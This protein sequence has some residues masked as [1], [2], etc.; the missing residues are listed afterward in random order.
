SKGTLRSDCKSD[1]DCKV[2]YSVC[3]PTT[4]RCVC[5]NSTNTHACIC[6]KRELY[7]ELGQPCTGSRQCAVAYSTCKNNVCSCQAG[8]ATIDG[9]CKSSRNYCPYF[10]KSGRRGLLSQK[11]CVQN[12][13]DKIID[14]RPIGNCSNNEYCFLHDGVRRP[15]HSKVGVCCLKPKYE[16]DEIIRVCPHSVKDPLDRSCKND[17]SSNMCSEKTHHC[18]MDQGRGICCPR[19]C[20]SFGN[21]SHFSLDGRC[22][23]DLLHGEYCTHD[24]ECPT[25]AKCKIS[26]H[27]NKDKT[28]QCEHGSSDGRHCNQPVAT[29]E[30]SNVP[31]KPNCSKGEVY[32]KCENHNDCTAHYSICNEKTKRCECHNSTQRHGCTCQKRALY[33]E[34]GQKCTDSHQ[35]AIAYSSCK[36]H[37]CTCKAGFKAMDGFCKAAG[38][39]C[40]YFR[41]TPQN[42]LTSNK[43]CVR[44][45]EQETTFNARPPGNC[46]ETEY[47]LIHDGVRTFQHQSVGFCCPRPYHQDDQTI[48]VCP[49]GIDDPQR[50]FCEENFYWYENPNA[51]PRETHRCVFYEEN[52]DGRCYPEA[53]HGEYCTVDIQCTYEAKCKASD[54]NKKDKTCQCDHGAVNGGGCKAPLEAA[55]NNRN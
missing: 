53:F 3:N 10:R 44:N 15:G 20:P 14:G 51:C 39:F 13:D 50:R 46:S 48:F 25:G 40:P 26:E 11:L 29:V 19:P 41:N 34:L 17:S 9:L 16:G 21:R 45:F 52:L 31:P 5:H 47:C 6:V 28:C 33:V 32:S 37:V 54:D 8:F 12:S 38:N 27:N 1:N 24:F 18:I 2:H 36:N 42:Q 23:A 7:I 55:G 30:D 22:Y 4:K 35:C 49:H 43:L